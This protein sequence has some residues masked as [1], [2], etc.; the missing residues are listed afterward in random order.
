MIDPIE[1]FGNQFLLTCDKVARKLHDDL[2]NVCIGD[3]CR[4]LVDDNHSAAEIFD[5]IACFFKEIKIVKNRR[6][7]LLAEGHGHGRKKHL[8]LDAVSVRLEFFKEHTLM[9]SVLVY[10][11]ELLALF[12]KYVGSERF[13]DHSVRLNLRPN[14]FR[15]NNRR[16]N[17]RLRLRFRSGNRL[18]H[19]RFEA[20]NQIRFIVL[21][22]FK[23]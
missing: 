21:F 3:C 15:L 2:G 11:Q 4:A 10:Y 7:F 16:C 14:G 20:R 22:Y 6:I 19:R 12:N 13:T 23:F 9:G 18:L 17:N 1:L 8:S 5:V